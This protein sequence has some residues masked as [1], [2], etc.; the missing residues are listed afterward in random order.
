MK[1]TQADLKPIVECQPQTI[2]HS[3]HEPSNLGSI[4]PPEGQQGENCWIQAP[5]RNLGSPTSLALALPFSF[6]IHFSQLLLRYVD[7]GW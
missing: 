6:S 4:V 1:R 2:Y 5:A 7:A 3:E